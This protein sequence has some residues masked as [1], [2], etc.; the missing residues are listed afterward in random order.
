MPWKETGPVFERVRFIDDYLSGCYTITE[1]ALMYDVSRKTLYK[2]LT[3]HDR[4]GISG[5]QDRS[6][7]PVRHASI[8]ED[9]RREIIEFRRRFPFMGPR[10]IVARLRELRPKAVWP[11]ASTVGDLLKREGLVSTRRR[12]RTPV[13]PLRAIPKPA[14][15][16]DVMTIDFKGQFKLGNRSYCY[17]LTIVDGFSRYILACE[18]LPSNEYDPTRRIFERVFRTYGL[19]RVILSDNGSPFGSPGLGRL[20]RLSVWWIRLGIAVQRIVPGHPEQNG[21][22]ERMHRTL[23]EQTARPPAASSAAQQRRFDRFRRE[24]NEERPHEA[25]GQRRPSTI[26][27]QSTRAYPEQLPQLEYPGHFETR[28]VDHAGQIKWKNKPIFLSHT[29]EHETVGFEEI[30]DGIWS[31]YYG[32]VMLARFNARAGRFFT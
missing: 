8:D 5:L 19:P 11:A 1:L 14:E 4:E 15:P 2:W 32:P 30:D 29:L 25:L 31:L 12:Q 18:A 23:K 27:S 26:Y 28:R 10:K 13:H 16:N 7:A 24:F 9:V 3:R 6:R 21:A 17:P 22:H 20:S